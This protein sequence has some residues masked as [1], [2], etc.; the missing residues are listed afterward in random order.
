MKIYLSACY[1]RQLEM[2]KVG[3]ELETFGHE[4]TSRWI[5]EE[6]FLG[7]EHRQPVSTRARR[8]QRNL[9]DLAQSDC[10]IAFT[11]GR[12]LARAAVAGMSSWGLPWPTG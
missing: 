8:A 4:I 3:R 2:Q 7:E 6:P 10:L 9:M 1:R 12:L 5:L 11:N